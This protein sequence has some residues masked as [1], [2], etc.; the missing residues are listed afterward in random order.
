MMKIK[1]ILFIN[2]SIN[3]LI[4]ILGYLPIEIK[5]VPEFPSINGLILMHS[6]CTLHHY[7]SAVSIHQWSDFNINKCQMKKTS[8]YKF[9]SINGLILIIYLKKIF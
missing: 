5:A 7:S 8:E 4:L 2:S 1:K 6:Y 3:G 9:P